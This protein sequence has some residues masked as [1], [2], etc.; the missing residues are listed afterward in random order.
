MWKSNTWKAGAAATSI[1]QKVV[2]AFEFS[3]GSADYWTQ[4]M[5]DSKTVVIFDIF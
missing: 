2:A 3:K 5:T 4:D 1:M